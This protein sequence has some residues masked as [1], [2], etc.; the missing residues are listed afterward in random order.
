MKAEQNFAGMTYGE[1]C[2]MMAGTEMMLEWCAGNQDCQLNV[3]LTCN[4]IMHMQAYITIIFFRY[5]CT[6]VIWRGFWV[7][8]IE[9][10]AVHW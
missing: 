10:C 5:L 6:T 2:V 8:I 1:L 4:N 9:I 3:M 7:N